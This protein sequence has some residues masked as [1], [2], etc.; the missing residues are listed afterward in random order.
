MATCT[1]TYS[2]EVARCA[3]RTYFWRK[4]GTLFGAS[5]LASVPLVI[6]AIAFIY[7]MQGANWFVGAF[8]LLLFF[9]MLMQWSYYFTLPRALAKRLTDPALRTAEITT[10]AD[11]VRI[12]IGPNASL[13]K[14]ARFKR[15]WLYDDFVILAM[16]PPL[17]MGFTYIPTAGMSTEVHRDLEAASQGNA[18]LI[19]PDGDA[20]IQLKS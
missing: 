6:G 5:Y 13:L 4:F 9:N 1:V 11:G 7:Y 15:I 14:W 19:P 16:N 12:V 8:G 3:A 10:S 18:H 2:P 17:Q 20:A